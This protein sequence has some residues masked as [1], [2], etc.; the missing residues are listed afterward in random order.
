MAINRLLVLATAPFLIGGFGFAVSNNAVAQS[1]LTTQNSTQPN[2]HHKGWG[3]KFEQLGLSDQQKTQIQQIQTSSHQKMAA[4]FTAEQK[5]QMQTA[6]Q[7][8]QRPTLNL[9]DD[10]KSQ[11]K[12]I[13]ES[14]KTQIDA[15]LTDAQKQKLQELKQQWQQN[16]QN[17]QPGQS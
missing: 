8:R 14:T 6:R 11:L 17:R 5:Q 15:V 12:A 3:K 16:R 2:G 10:Q 1:A 7:Q 13:G 9:T 4:V